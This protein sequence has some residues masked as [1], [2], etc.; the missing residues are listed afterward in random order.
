MTCNSDF[1]KVGTQQTWLMVSLKGTVDEEAKSDFYP[2][3][4]NSQSNPKYFER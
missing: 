1:P 4:F 2:T 3:I